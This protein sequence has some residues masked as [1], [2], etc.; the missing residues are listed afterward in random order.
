MF[1]LETF[2]VVMNVRTEL[3]RDE[4]MARGFKLISEGYF[5]SE[6][7]FG[8]EE[9]VSDEEDLNSKTVPELKVIAKER[10]IENYSSM[11]RN[12]LLKVLS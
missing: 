8:S 2:G 4:L 3:E 6:S 12:E 11:K 10:E 5:S 9:L 1:T 7:Q